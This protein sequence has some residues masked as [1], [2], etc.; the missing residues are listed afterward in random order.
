MPCSCA[1]I[2]A[3]Q[4]EPLAAHHASQMIDTLLWSKYLTWGNIGTPTARQP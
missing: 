1:Y 3:V 4:N 2:T